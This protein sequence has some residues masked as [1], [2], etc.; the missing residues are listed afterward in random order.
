MVPRETL[1]VLSP[2]NN[3]Y[4]NEKML[5]LDALRNIIFKSDFERNIFLTVLLHI[6]YSKELVLGQPFRSFPFS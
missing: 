4:D 2:A 3:D 1:G 5:N 6:N